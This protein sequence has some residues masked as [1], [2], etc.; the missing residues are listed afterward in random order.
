MDGTQMVCTLEHKGTELFA[1]E[2]KNCHKITPQN[3]LC[4]YRYW[5]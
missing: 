1:R 3:R 5:Q 4:G 2:L